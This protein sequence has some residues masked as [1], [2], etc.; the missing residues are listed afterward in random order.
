MWSFCFT[1]CWSFQN[2]RRVNPLLP[3]FIRVSDATRLTCV[4]H[5]AITAARGCQFSVFLPATTYIFHPM[6]RFILLLPLICFSALGFAQSPQDLAVPVKISTGINPPA[7]LISWP[8]PVPSDVVLRRRV[9]G[10]AG[11]SWVELV[12]APATLLDGYFDLGLSGDAVYEYEVELK[13]NGNA[14]Y[15]YAFASFFT[16]VI[17]WVPTSLPLKTICGA[18]A[19]NQCH[20][21]PGLPPPCNG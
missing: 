8:N 12:N 3:V 20:L 5:P 13:R 16:P 21:K 15:G 1:G 4:A 14:A 10:Q 9:K 19:G 11:N 6:S 2:R 18:K 7:V 17:D